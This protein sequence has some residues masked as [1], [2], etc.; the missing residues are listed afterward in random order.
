MLEEGLALLEA[1]RRQAPQ[2][3]EMGPRILLRHLHRSLQVVLWVV[4][5]GLPFLFLL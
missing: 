1:V 5:P 4:L 3:L 2:R